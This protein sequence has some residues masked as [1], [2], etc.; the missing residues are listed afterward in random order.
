MFEFFNKI[1]AVYPYEE[2]QRY[3]PS[4]ATI[5]HS[6]N[7]DNRVFKILQNTEAELTPE[8]VSAVR[9]LKVQSITSQSQQ[10][11]FSEDTHDFASLCLKKRKISDFSRQQ[12]VDCRF[13]LPTSNIIERFFSTAGYTF[14][15]YRQSL[16][17]MN[18]EMRLFLIVNRSFWDQ[19]LV[20]K[21][22][23]E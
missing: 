9:M 1:L 23:T 16:L 19:V 20:L 22:Y 18:L 15:D 13:L 11:D 17:P 6:P 10:S 2:F 8:E 5:V 4:S 14:N 3:L 7:F 21:I 12:Y